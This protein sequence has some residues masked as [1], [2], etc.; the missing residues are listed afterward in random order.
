MA[1]VKA[2]LSSTHPDLASEFY[3][4]DIKGQTQRVI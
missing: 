3:L 2:K 4:M 1:Q